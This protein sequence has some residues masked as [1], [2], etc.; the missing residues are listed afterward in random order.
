MKLTRT[1]QYFIAFRSGQGFSQALLC[2]SQFVLKSS[3]RTSAID[4]TDSGYGSGQPHAEII[5]C[6]PCLDTNL[7]KSASRIPHLLHTTFT[8]SGHGRTGPLSRAARVLVLPFA[9]P[10]SGRLRL[11]LCS[12]FA[13]IMTKMICIPCSSAISRWHS[14]CLCP[15]IPVRPGL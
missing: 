9:D 11:P 14:S 5:D 4:K 6:I 1:P 8:E 13:S 12:A 10:R 3:G 2:Q 7:P 15:D